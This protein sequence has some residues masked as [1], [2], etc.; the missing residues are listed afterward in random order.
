MHHNLVL[1]LN[2][3]HVKPLDFHTGWYSFNYKEGILTGRVIAIG[4][5]FVTISTL[6]MGM[7]KMKTLEFLDSSFTK[8]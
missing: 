8:L 6:T 5:E 7:I 4:E 2:L 3:P 1:P